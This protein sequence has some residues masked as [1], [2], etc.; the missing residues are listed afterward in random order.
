MRNTVK[1][2]LAMIVCLTMILPLQLAAAP[3]ALAAAP[4]WTAV[5]DPGF[6]AGE[7]FCTS[8]AIADDG[9]LY[10]AYK[11]ND[12]KATVMKYSGAVAGWELVGSAGFSDGTTDYISLVLADGAPYVAYQDG[13]DWDNDTNVPKKATVMKYSGTSWE[14]VGNPRFS[15]ATANY[16]SLAF[17][18]ETPYIAYS[19]VGNGEKATVMRYDGIGWE[20]MGSAGFSAGK[21]FHTSL[22][23]DSGGTPYVAYRD[24]GNG[25]KA[26]VMKYTNAGLTGWKEAGGPGGFS[27]GFAGDTSLAVDDAGNPYVAYQDS[28][29]GEKATVMKYTGVGWEL[30][31]SAGFSAGKATDISLVIG[32]GGMPYV[33]YK[34]W[35][36]G[37][38][39]ATVMK[40]TDAGWE[41][42]GSPG[43]SAGYID[44]TSLAIGSDGT[45]YV[46]YK[47]A[48][49]ANKATVM[50]YIPDID[51]PHL[52]LGGVSRSS[53][54]AAT[55]SFTTN[56]EGEY[57]YEVVAEGAGEPALDTSGPGPACGVGEQTVTL[58]SLSA[59]SW[60]IYIKVKDDSGNVSDTLK[61]N[62]PALMAGTPNLTAAAGSARVNL[63]WTPVAGSVSYSVYQRSTSPA[64][65]SALAS[66]ASSV[67]SYDVTGLTNNTTYYFKVSAVDSYG[68][69]ADSNE[70]SA[71]PYRHSSSSSSK[72][73]PTVTTGE[74]TSVDETTATLQGK[75]ESDGNAAITEY[76]F[77]YGTDK[78]S[79]TQKEKAGT[80]NYRGKFSYELSGLKAGNT[81][82]YKAYAQSGDAVL[83]GDVLSFTTEETVQ[84]E[85]E[86]KQMFSDVPDTHWAYGSINQLCQKG[87]V[88]GYEDGSFRPDV[89]ITRAEF[90]TILVKALDLQAAATAQNFSDTA[91]HWAQ[92]SIAA[93]VSLGI[94]DGYTDGSFQPDAFITREQMAVMAVK[95]AGVTA[96]S[97]ETAFTDNDQISFWAKGSVLAAIDANIMEGYPDNTFRPQGNATRAEAVCVILNLWVIK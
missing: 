52:T 15:A 25:N 44:Y 1:R 95:A 43:F 75:I 58:T 65:G 46:A 47:D 29:K 9:T 68:N 79:L 77:M 71:T 88:S 61:M 26:T 87:A 14:A 11:G 17:D 39:K 41:A 45:L 32:S 92:E 30:V 94:A 16:I 21:A 27:A 12:N 69:T 22:A 60:D 63:S 86:E 3:T 6:S 18:G 38:G 76:G 78:S 62:I 80:G 56:E 28:D 96:G 23:I 20:L 49:N 4:E 48:A 40:Y 67:Y 82:Y 70:A 2:T 57:Y 55:V 81:Y 50:Q 42:V 91:D 66:V 59:G 35:G 85:P 97:G 90:I 24:N 36:T 34:D 13:K 72:S 37:G 64:Y 93:A 74:S 10:V 19:D 89:P 33:A 83:Y 54:S 7:A 51:A 73:N 53:D 5:G 8:L 31:G 84:P